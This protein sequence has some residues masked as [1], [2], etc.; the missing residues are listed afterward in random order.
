MIII[1][2]PF[3]IKK[4]KTDQ[5]RVANSILA[6]KGYTSKYA[7]SILQFP[8]ESVHSLQPKMQAKSE[9]LQIFALKLTLEFSQIKG[10]LEFQPR[11]L[12]DW[13]CHTAEEIDILQEKL[14]N[15]AEWSF[16]IILLQTRSVKRFHGSQF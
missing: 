9:F 10:S 14:E 3:S 1:F 7:V 5:K 8:G 15:V 2:I 11:S 16:G 6:V 12:A 13:L 4:A